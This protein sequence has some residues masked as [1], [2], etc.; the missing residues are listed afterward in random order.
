VTFDVANLGTSTAQVTGGIIQWE[1]PQLGLSS[2]YP[3]LNSLGAGER[4]SLSFPVTIPAL[5]AGTYAFEAELTIF[6]DAR[7]QVYES[8]EN[9]N[10]RSIHFAVQNCATPVPTPTIFIGG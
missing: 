1:I 4:I 2:F 6:V 9:D 7:N 3:G 10:T 5:N 8:V